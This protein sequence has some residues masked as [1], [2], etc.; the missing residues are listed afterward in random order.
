MSVKNLLLFPE[1]LRKLDN[2]GCLEGRDSTLTLGGQVVNAN[3]LTMSTNLTD[4][5]NARSAVALG[6]QVISVASAAIRNMKSTKP[7]MKPKKKG[8][9]R[10]NPSVKHFILWHQ[11]LKYKGKQ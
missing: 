11:P 10:E 7:Y 3:I 9:K 6:L 5:Q 8:N 2:G 4:Q 1:G